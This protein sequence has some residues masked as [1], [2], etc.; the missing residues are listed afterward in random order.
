MRDYD[1]DLVMFQFD[2]ISEDGKPLTSSYKHNHYDD[3]II[4]TPVEAIKAQVKAE[5]DGYFWSFVAAASIYR[6]HGFSFPVGAR[7]RTWPVS[8][9]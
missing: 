6:N 9:M 4:M 1:A 7:L 8:A 3:V 5:I 2:T